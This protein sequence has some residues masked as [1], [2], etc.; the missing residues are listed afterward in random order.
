LLWSARGSGVEWYRV[1]FDPRGDC[2]SLGWWWCLV[3]TGQA[4]TQ[5][6][7]DEQ[8][9]GKRYSS[10]SAV[11][12]TSPVLLRRSQ[13]GVSVSTNVGS[14]LCITNLSSIDDEHLKL[15]RRDYSVCFGRLSCGKIKPSHICWGHYLLASGRGVHLTKKDGL[16]VAYRVSCLISRFYPQ[17]VRAKIRLSCLDQVCSIIISLMSIANWT[18]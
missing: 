13:K 6:E 4:S 10:S 15:S 7:E 11:H 3:T 2:I 1:E 12:R 17:R 14:N 18:D 8:T 5:A 16:L 9:K